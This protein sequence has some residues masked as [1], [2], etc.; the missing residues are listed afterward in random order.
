MKLEL[1]SLE[2]P[3]WKGGAWNATFTVRADDDR[4]VLK[5]S[6][7]CRGSSREDQVHGWKQEVS[8]EQALKKL[9]EQARE[10]L[11]EAA[12]SI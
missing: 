5:F 10:T 3:R 8:A 2:Y 6:E 1:E 9:F 4:E 11:R 7:T 12:G